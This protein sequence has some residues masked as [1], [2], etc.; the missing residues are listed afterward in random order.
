MP[1]IS[2]DEG[3]LNRI[4]IHRE[5]PLEP[6]VILIVKFLIISHS[7]MYLLFSTGRSVEQRA[8]IN[9]REKAPGFM[10]GFS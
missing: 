1:D 7:Q 9:A 3:L 8:R 2:F 5:R 10:S 6:M 4:L